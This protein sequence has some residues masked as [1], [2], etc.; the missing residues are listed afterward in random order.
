MRKILVLGLIILGSQITWAIPQPQNLGSVG[1][2]S[3]FG[4]FV[5]TLAQIDA[6]TPDTT[7]QAV[8]CSD[9]KFVLCISTAAQSLGRGGFVV[10]GSTVPAATSVGAG[11]G[12]PMHC[13]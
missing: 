5:R 4:L 13:Q 7:G 11:T 12:N 3:P 1:T 10:V 6:L 2:D 8:V 9:C